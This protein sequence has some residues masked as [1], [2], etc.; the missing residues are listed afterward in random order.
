MT[1]QVQQLH[2]VVPDPP[3]TYRLPVRASLVI[4]RLAS[5]QQLSAHRT[6]KLRG[7]CQLSRLGGTSGNLVP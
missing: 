5:Q 1:D 4:S 6:H 3:T 7:L 2:V